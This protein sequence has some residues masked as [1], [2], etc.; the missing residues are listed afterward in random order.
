M[1]GESVEI[2][3]PERFRDRHGR[4]V[5]DYFA[6]PERREMG[7]G[8]ELL[9]IRAD[10]SEIVMNAR[11]KTGMQERKIPD[12]RASSITGCRAAAS[13]SFR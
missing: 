8:M 4:Q 6:D 5:N 3:I 2:L 9:G 13:Q 1:V 11:M 7:E 10:G 12:S